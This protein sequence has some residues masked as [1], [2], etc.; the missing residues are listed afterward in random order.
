MAKTGPKPKAHCKRG[1]DMAVHRKRTSGGRSY[2]QACIIE[3]AKERYQRDEDFRAKNS[4]YRKEQFRR[5]K[6]GINGEQ[7]QSMLAAQQFACAICDNSLIG[8]KVCVDHDHVTE[9][10][11]GLLCHQCNVALG[12]FRDRTD[13]LEKAVRYLEASRVL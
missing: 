6:Y 3:K 2:C 5:L 8:I 9:V 12:H 7:F 10:V 4:T 11:R 13:L 1:H